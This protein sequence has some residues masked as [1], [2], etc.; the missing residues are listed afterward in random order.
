MIPVHIVTGFLGSGKT[1]LLRDVLARPEFRDTAVIVN[2]WGEVGLDHYLLETVEEGVLLLPSGCVCCQV[3]DDLVTTLRDLQDR[4]AKGRIPRFARV[5]LETTG[6]A[7]PAPVASTL[8]ADPVLR[9][10]FR[11]GSIICT[12]DAQSFG[13]VLS[14]HPEV[15]K[16]AAVADRI[17]ITKC[18]LAD[19]GPT[20]RAARGVNPLAMLVRSPGQR[21]DA[22]LL[23]GEEAAD[24]DRR[25]AAAA[26]FLAAADAHDGHGHHRHGPATASF[27]IREPRPIDWTAFGIWLSALL[28]AHGDRVLRVK[29]ILNV[30]ESAT[31]VILNGVQ[32]AVHPPLHLPRWPDADRSSRIV[33]IVRGLE[34]AAI[35]ASLAAFLRLAARLRA[36]VM[37]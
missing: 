12:A 24:P 6:L 14:V 23:F 3:R 13:A 10:Q 31:P 8:L 26:R 33:F 15:E 4:A 9:H 19:P 27:V 2:E 28:H 21:L 32:H 30:A 17:V 16:Q 35:R 18:D 25:A 7:D 29:G 37:A 11:L 36:G 5:V 34:E 1:T 22:E 20:E